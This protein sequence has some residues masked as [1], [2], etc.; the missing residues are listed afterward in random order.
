M[1][2]SLAAGRPYAAG[3]AS[4]ADGLLPVRPGDLTFAH[5]RACVDEVGRWTTE[6]IVNAVRWLFCDATGMRG[7]AERRRQRAA[8]LAAGPAETGV[9]AVISGGNVD[10]AVFQAVTAA[11]PGNLSAPEH[12]SG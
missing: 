5:V 10:P 9:V 6:S 3:T 2:A 8:A 11:R 12:V 4:I 1:T 7:R